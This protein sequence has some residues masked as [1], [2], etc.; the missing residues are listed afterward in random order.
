MKKEKI[1]VVGLWLVVAY[2]VSLLTYITFDV[3]LK[4]DEADISAFGSIL[5]S[6]AGFA[7]CLVAVYLYSSWQDQKKYEL[8]KEYFQ[9]ISI[10]FF[11][12]HQRMT[13]DTIFYAAFYKEFKT[14]QRICV[15]N[16]SK[17][18]YTLNIEK[19]TEILYLLEF[20]SEFEKIDSIRSDFEIYR[21][22]ASKLTY[23]NQKLDEIYHYGY[24]S[25]YK[26][27]PLLSGLI[28]NPKSTEWSNINIL[29][30][31]KLIN[32]MNVNFKINENEFSYSE[33][34]SELKAIYNRVYPDLAR[35]INPYQI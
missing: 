17:T 9:K 11:D 19:E 14:N 32:E 8:K 25:I 34:L 20:V 28:I 13:K 22:I 18:N 4:K 16:I 33:L 3:F 2:A 21:L 5:S 29:V 31:V 23:M 10:S 7:A 6:V 26:N 30:A 1:L 27:H 24:E 35:L 15:A 12:F